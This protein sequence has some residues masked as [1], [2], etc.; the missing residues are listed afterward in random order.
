MTDHTHCP[1]SI[2]RKSPNKPTTSYTWTPKHNILT[3]TAR[4]GRI[5]ENLV[6]Y[7]LQSRG[8]LIRERNFETRKGEIDIIASR[9]NEDLRGY[10]TI[11]F[12]EVKSRTSAHG[13]SPAM[14]VTESKRRKVT[15]TMQQWI[16]AHPFEKAVYRCDIA[17]IILEHAKAPRITYY[18]SAFC[19]HEQF[20]W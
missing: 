9:M 12:I 6:I 20:G 17:A 8:W 19:A 2:S 5:G 15:H 16:G 1:R 13:L 7:Y 11:A 4:T 18:P 10:P 3:K 14:N